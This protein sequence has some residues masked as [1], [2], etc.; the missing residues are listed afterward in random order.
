M[1]GRRDDVG[2]FRLRCLRL[3]LRLRGIGGVSISG[4]R[5]HGGRREGRREL[6]I[7]IREGGGGWEGKERR[8]GQREL[9]EEVVRI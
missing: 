1:A 2:G 5:V 7:R 9:G 6:F 4:G 8:D 3:A